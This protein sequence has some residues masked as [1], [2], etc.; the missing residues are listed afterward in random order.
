MDSGQIKVVSSNVKKA[1][2]PFIS[3]SEYV[4]ANADITRGMTSPPYSLSECFSRFPSIFEIAKTI[5]LTSGYAVDGVTGTTFFNLWVGPGTGFTSPA[6]PLGSR[7]YDQ[8]QNEDDDENEKNNTDTSNYGITGTTGGPKDLYLEK[9]STEC[10]EVYG[11]TALG[12]G[13]LGCFWGSPEATYSCICPE[14]QE[15][16]EAYLKLRLNVATFWNTP[17]NVPVKREE[18]LDE[19]KFGRK[20]EIVVAGD[21]SYK[22]GTVVEIS[23]DGAAS[24]A[25]E[26]SSILN[27]KYWI[28]GIKHNITNSG[29]HETALIL[30]KTGKSTPWSNMKPED[31]E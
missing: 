26:Y 23:V 18:F 19:L 10:S 8:K 15:K 24:Y 2:L 31:A 13:W 25:V 9:P 30:S 14:I 7:M 22:L 3:E 1:I 29:T 28:I 17:K 16:Y 21:F 27:G 11:S 20:V 5:G 12:P 6:L 4:C